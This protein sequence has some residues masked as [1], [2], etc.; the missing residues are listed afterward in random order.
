MGGKNTA[1]RIVVAGN[2]RIHAEL[3]AE[4]VQRDRTIQVVGCASSSREVFEIAARSSFDVAV[5]SS[6]LDE[7]PDRGFEVLRKLRSA[8]PGLQAIMLLD[9][10]KSQ[11]VVNAFRAGAKGVF[12]K[13]SPLTGLSKCIRCVQEG[14]IWASP[15]ELGLALDTLTTTP[16]IQAL[17]GQGISLLTK[18]EQAV[19]E[20]VAEGLTTHEIARHLQLSTHTVK[21]Y[22]THIFDKLGVS[23]RV[24]LLFF[25]LARSPLKREPISNHPAFGLE[26]AECFRSGTNVPR[27]PM[28]A[29]VWCLINEKT[30]L[31][32][33]TQIAAAKKRLAESMTL[34][35][36]LDAKGQA[37]SLAQGGSAICPTGTE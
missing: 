11:S 3:L 17:D 35:Q 5:I 8:H 24:E 18:R 15:E 4:A 31:K 37:C 20:C 28:A 32:A 14:Q 26:V 21:N 7:Q 25:V 13:N 36:I 22:L 34:E 1:H 33:R 19:V 9:S 10:A 12:S 29:Y 2:T 16:A 30:I 6:H 23:N 27:D